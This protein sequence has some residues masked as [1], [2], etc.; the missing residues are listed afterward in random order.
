MEMASIL[1]STI[2]IFSLHSLKC[3]IF[4]RQDS[5]I[6]CLLPD[7]VKVAVDGFSSLFGLSH[8]D[9]DIWITGASFILGLETLSTQHWGE[10]KEASWSAVICVCVCVWMQTDVS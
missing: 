10:G 3:H 9:G 1:I 2:S 6:E 4:F 5:Q 8:L 7:R